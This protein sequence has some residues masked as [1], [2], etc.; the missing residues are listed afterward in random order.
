MHRFFDNLVQVFYC[1]E[2]DGEI[3]YSEKYG[4]VRCRNSYTVTYVDAGRNRK[5]GLIQ[6]FFVSP[7]TTILP[8]VVIKEVKRCAKTLERHFSI[9][10][11]TIHS[12]S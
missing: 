10:T 6:Y 3:Y 9:T 5:F 4:S 7:G 8:L 1:V 11:S 12:A 2:N